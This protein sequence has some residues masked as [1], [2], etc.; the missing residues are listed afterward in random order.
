MHWHRTI[1]F[2]LLAISA[3]TAS[4]QV[5]RCKDAAG[6]VTFSDSPCASGQAG[7]QIQRKRTQ[8]EILQ[9]RIQAAEAEDR[10]Q[11]RRMAEQEREWAEQQRRAMQ[12]QPAPTV[13]HS[14]NDWQKRNELRN[15]EVSA[16]SITNNGGRWDAAAQAERARQRR[17]EARRNPPT[18]T[19]ITNCNQGFCYDEHGGV[20]HRNGPDFMTGPN[21]RTCNRAGNMWN[22]N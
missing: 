9:E 4:A 14:G 10:K 12:P 15:A 5:H 3:V 22:C 13:R 16:R 19:I 11:G 2:I 17:E 8:D 6:K 1:I 21:G 18:P 20:Y 7:E